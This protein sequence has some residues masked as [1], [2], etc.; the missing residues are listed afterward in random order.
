MYIRGLIPRN[1]QDLAEAVLIVLYA[2]EH[3]ILLQSDTGTANWMN[4]PSRHAKSSSSWRTLLRVT[5]EDSRYNVIHDAVSSK[6]QDAVHAFA[7]EV[8]LFMP[9]AQS[10]APKLPNI[11]FSSIVSIDRM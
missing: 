6:L 8:F 4:T 9:L 2:A 3:C 10:F 7:W 5:T 1:F 11:H